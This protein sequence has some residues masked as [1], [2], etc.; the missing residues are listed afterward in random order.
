MLIFETIVQEIGAEAALFADDK[1]LILFG[2]NAPEG[3]K[4]YAYQI[5]INRAKEEIT[6]E[7]ILAI[8]KTDFKIT[9]VGNL[10]TKNLNQLGHITMKFT[11]ETTA[12]LPGTLYLEGKEIPIITVGT[13]ITIGQKMRII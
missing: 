11:G 4:E 12:E 2:D 8:G 10:V 9:A 5:I 1:M 7:M 6:T 13:K 3:L